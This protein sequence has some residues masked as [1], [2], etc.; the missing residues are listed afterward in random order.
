MNLHTALSLAALSLAAALFLVP[1]EQAA[2]CAVAP[3]SGDSVQIA[4]ESAIIVWDAASKTQ[5]FIRR[6]TF[7]S[8]AR[9]FGFLVPTPT[10]PT[11]EEVGD[12]AFTTLA[13]LTKPKVITRTMPSSGGGCGFCLGSVAPKSAA[14]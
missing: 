10:Q 7:A 14:R 8:G 4:D 1:A 6:A 12:E 11:L 3:H 13:E 9:D 2:G 5:H